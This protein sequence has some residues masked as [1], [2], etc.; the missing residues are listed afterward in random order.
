LGLR[1]MV[2]GASDF[3]W[4]LFHA[5]KTGAVPVADAVGGSVASGHGA[6]TD[7]PQGVLMA[8]LGFLPGRVIADDFRLR[9][10]FAQRLEHQGFGG[11]SVLS[12]HADESGRDLNPIHLIATYN[13]I[14]GVAATPEGPLQVGFDGDRLTALQNKV[15]HDSLLWEMER[16][17]GKL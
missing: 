7:S 14:F 3:D 10:A 1:T 11:G 16:P 8:A 4:N 13:G 12:I 17:A 15:T 5:S 6:Y 9:S 2:P